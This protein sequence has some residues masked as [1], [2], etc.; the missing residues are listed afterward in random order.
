[1]AKQ[2]PKQLPDDWISGNKTSLNVATDLGLRGDYPR[3]LAVYKKKGTEKLG[4]RWLP[5]KEEDTRPNKGRT[6]KK[7]GGQGKRKY[8]EGRTGC[9]D[10]FQAGKAAIN[11]SVEQRQKLQLA[12][13]VEK[14][15]SNHSLHYYWEIW[16]GRFSARSDKSARNKRDRLNQW[17]GEGWGLA[18]QSFSHKS[19]ED[20]NALDLED[21]FS[22]LEK[23]GSG[24][25]GS[26]AQ[27]KENQRTLLNHLN[28]E[29]RK[30]FPSLQ[31]FIF[32][33]ITRVQS[34]VEHFTKSEW[35][36]IVK[37]VIELSGGIA[38]TPLTEKQYQ[39]LEWTD[40]DIFNK[41]NWVDFYDCLML[42]W[43]FYLRAE[44]MPRIKSEWF[45]DDEESKTIFVYLE[46]TK[47]DRLKQN[48]EHLRP[49]GYSN[50]K[51]I[52]RRKPNG[53]VAFPFYLREE[54][55]ENASH[56]L[57]TLNKMLKKVVQLCGIKKRKVVWTIN[58]HTAF[59]LTL[60]EHPDLGK[61]PDIQF[62]AA[63]GNTSPEM[64]RE[65]YLKYI[66]RGK[67]ASTAR[68]KLK[69]SSWSLIKRIKM[70]ANPPNS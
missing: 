68:E 22:L 17:N 3:N 63:N 1:M 30:D 56:V 37:K 15:N 13:Q 20:I 60:E 34:Q 28:K 10:P 46:K 40:R 51:K 8:I 36:K 62:F 54:G 41:R 7:G 59:R 64:L 61:E 35:D 14:Y 12:N 49:D 52:E 24:K 18:E 58:R 16:Y 26:M 32:P 21:Y 4:C 48:T 66:Q 65:T 57:E 67:V 29:A 38:D 31:P 47:Q 27:M 44:D 19:V 33:T 43:F 39:Q 45:K 9:E 23:R 70:E 2:M 55:N 25:K 53:Y 6:I 11:W 42:M 69:E 50:W 5:S